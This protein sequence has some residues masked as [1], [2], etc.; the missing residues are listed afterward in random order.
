MT[1]KWIENL[2]GSLEQKRR[3][4]QLGA[5]IDTLPEP[6]QGVARAFQRYFM[7]CGGFT[8]GDTLV[9]MFS[10]FVDLWERASIDGTPVRVIVGDDPI[11]FAETFARA[12]SGKQWID[13]ERTRLIT[14][15]HDAE[16]AE[17]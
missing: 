1:K 3:Y 4:R 6:Y 15:I 2:T 16:R 7:Y 14:A 5:R 9:T 12:Y 13:G 17:P 8:D 11:D 10:D